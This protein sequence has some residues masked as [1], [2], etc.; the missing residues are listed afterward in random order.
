MLMEE[1]VKE[2]KENGVGII[3]VDEDKSDVFGEGRKEIA[4]VAWIENCGW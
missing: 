2:T 3:N 4:N 1:F